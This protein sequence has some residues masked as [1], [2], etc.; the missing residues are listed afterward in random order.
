MLEH[1][2]GEMADRNSANQDILESIREKLDEFNSELM[3]L[4]DSLNDAVKNIAKASENHSVNQ[5]IVEEYMVHK[6]SH[7]HTHADPV[8]HTGHFITAQI[9]KDTPQIETSGVWFILLHYVKQHSGF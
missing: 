5:K 4:R 9:K 3:K 7:T 2:K 1:V 6:P 8:F